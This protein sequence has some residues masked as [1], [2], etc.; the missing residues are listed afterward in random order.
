[1]NLDETA[2]EICRSLEDPYEGVAVDR[3][4]GRLIVFASPG[5]RD[6]VERE[7]SSVKFAAMTGPEIIEGKFK[8][9]GSRPHTARDV[10]SS[11]GPS[12][13]VR[14]G[15]GARISV[16]QGKDGILACFVGNQ[17][18]RP[19]GLTTEHIFKLR[20]SEAVFQGR[21]KIGNFSRDGRLGAWGRAAA[22]CALFSIDSEVQLEHGT[23]SSR[24]VAAAALPETRGLKV[25]RH[26]DPDRTGEVVTES[27]CVRYQIVV[28]GDLKEVIV[29]KQILIFDRDQEFV[30]D[31]E[32][33]ALILMSQNGPGPKPAF[34]KGDPLAIC[35][36]VFT[37]EK[38]YVASPLAT[39]LPL[40]E[41]ASIIP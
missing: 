34:A 8:A 2:Q 23:L 31:G 17:S 24:Y 11:P 13:A 15:A 30:L 18:Q 4:K 40:L 32:S 3:R 25:H 6:D 27:C 29:E 26:D 12:G 5:R 22:D 36:G 35:T 39:C 1:M 20:S 9:L 38:Y 16:E 41:V 37:G 7:L 14:L 10:A 33:G 21:D 28:A 19:L